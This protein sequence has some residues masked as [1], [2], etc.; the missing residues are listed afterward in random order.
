[1][2]H[3][4]YIDIRIDFHFVFKI[5]LWNTCEM[6]KSGF[7]VPELHPLPKGFPPENYEKYM[8]TSK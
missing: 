1:M 2:S 4:T 3:Y 6:N 8:Y 5:I 7:K